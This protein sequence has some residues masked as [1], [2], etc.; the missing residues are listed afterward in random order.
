MPGL[1]GRSVVQPH[2]GLRRVVHAHP[3]KDRAGHQREPARDPACAG[4]SVPAGVWL[5]RPRAGDAERP[6]EPGPFDADLREHL[7]QPAGGGHREHRRTMERGAAERHRVG[8]A[9]PGND[10]HARCDD[11]LRRF[12]RAACDGGARARQRDA[13][14]EHPTGRADKSAG[15]P[16]VRVA[17]LG[18][19]AAEP[20]SSFRA[21]PTGN[22]AGV[23]GG[24]R[25]DG[26]GLDLASA[27][28]AAAGS[29]GRHHVR[30]RDA[31]RRGGHRGPRLG[32]VG[33]GP[34]VCPCLPRWTK[35]SCCRWCS[36]AG[37]AARGSKMRKRARSWPKTQKPPAPCSRTSGCRRR[38][39]RR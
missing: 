21:A 25:V 16:A 24:I 29:S 34:D 5:H 15:F 13:R 3:A 10:Q 39:A 12:L 23:V 18:L 26:G 19:R 7:R 33:P 37:A 1:P 38:A 30:R 27:P 4:Q 28:D 32:P 35:P 6:G 2:G 8:L 11:S 17:L 9:L 20:V 31:A 14:R 36:N 22:A